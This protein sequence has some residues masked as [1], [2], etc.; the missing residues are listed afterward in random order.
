M[1][2]AS[3]EGIVKRLA[4]LRSQLEY[5]AKRYYVDDDPEI[6]DAEYDQL[7]RELLTLEKAF[8][9]LVTA[10]SPSQRVGGA[11]LAGF[12]SLRRDIPMLSLDNAFSD[13]ELLKFDEQVRNFLRLDAPIPYMAE[14]K[15]DGLAVELVYV[16]GI[17]RHGT[18]RGDGLTGEDI[19][20]N[21][22]TIETIPL[23]IKPSS[24][25]TTGSLSI[26][27]EVFMTKEA[28]A[29]LNAL[30]QRA[31]EPIF[32]NPRNAAAGSLRQL[33]PAIARKRHLDFFPYGVSIP[34]ATGK[35]TQAELL[36]TF[37][38]IGFH[39]PD[40]H[41]LCAS[42]N[43]VIDYYNFLLAN[44]ASLPYEIDGVVVK[45]NDFVL[46]QRLGATNRTP[47]WAIARKFPAVQATTILRDILFSVGRTGAVTP[48]ALLDPVQVGGVTVSRAT[49]H[50]EDEIVRK[51]I[52]IGDTVLVQRA[53]DV[54]PE[55]VKAITGNRKGTEVPVIFP[56]KCPE[57]A[58]PLEKGDKI[59]RCPNTQLCPAQKIQ[60]LIH[61]TGKSGLDIEGLGKRVVHQLL[62]FGLVQDIPD[63]FRL[64]EEQ[65]SQLD[66]WG[67]KSAANVI[68]AIN[69]AK[70]GTTLGRFLCAIGIRHIG[71]GSADLLENEFGSLDRVACASEETLLCID[72]I[73][74][75]S[76]KAIH[77]YF[78]DS[79]HL[80]M[81]DE[82][83]V[84]GLTFEAKTKKTHLPLQGKVFLFTGTL[85]IFS[86]NEA[87]N[88]VK[89]LGGQVASSLSNKV[90]H[91]VA[92]E[93]AG[94]KLTKAA[95]LGISII[96]EGAFLEML[97]SE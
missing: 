74:K 91:L 22:R 88:K 63:I 19:T 47:R 25:P 33:D 4:K 2:M 56:I 21:L 28:F 34:S 43:D 68:G 61:F 46:Q 72:G 78:Q 23:R 52:M 85:T 66:G 48:V 8:P 93:K 27:G 62:S 18:T 9:E 69:K 10:D 6:A 94:S 73:G 67:T 12:T 38:T 13:D 41:R 5:H 44:R 65:L 97:G 39:L 95:D 16:D 79:N 71:E 53:G 55:I 60:G 76:A 7:F 37:T 57:C 90:T 30:R 49:L 77:A 17:L 1:T 86:R 26:R 54:I 40:Q 51:E 29:R 81:L 35:D 59:Y 24:L 14:P 11:P 64:T 3:P 82:L 75:E 96:T 83:K 87:K 80:K 84:L 89:E 32:A 50:N 42:I 58:T 15:L 70:T 20:Q 92:A 31:S 36:E 45:V